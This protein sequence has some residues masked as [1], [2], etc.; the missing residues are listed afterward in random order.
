MLKR[1]TY[2]LLFLSALLL[3]SLPAIGKTIHVPAQQPTIQAGINAASN[4]D[5]VLVSAG[6]YYES[7][8]FSGKAITVTSASGPAVTMIDGPNNQNNS[9]VT[10]SS[11]ETLS[12]VISGFTI[13]SS[14]GLGININGSSPTVKGNVITLSCTAISAFS[15]AAPLIQ[16]NLIA[17]NDPSSCGYGGGGISAEE[18]S[19]VQILGNV[20]SANG[21]TAIS[22]YQASGSV[23]VSQNTV[24]QNNGPGVFIFGGGGP[25]TVIQNLITGNQGSGLSW[26]QPPMTLISNTVASNVPGCCGTAGSEINASDVDNTVVLENNLVVATGTAPAFYCGYEAV[27]PTL[28]NNDIFS[29]NGVAYGGACPDVT[30][31]SGNLSSDPL[32]VDFLSDN[33]L[34]Q[35]GSPAVNAGTN[36]APNEPTTDFV[37]DPRIV[38]GTIDIGA[39]EYSPTPSLALASYA[40]HFGAVDVG[41]SSS[42]Q[43][44]TLTNNST[45]AVSISLI[46]TGA[47]Y[48][49]TNTCGK[50]LAAGGSCQISVTFTPVSGGAVPGALGI[51]TGAT[52]NPL[53]V[54]LL[55][56]GLAPQVQIYGNFYFYGQVIGTPATQTGTL[57]NVG[58]GPLAIS[59]IVYNGASDFVETNNC[60]IAPNTLAVQ[61]YCTISVTYTPTIIGSESGTIAFNDNALPSPQTVNVQGS[62]VSAGV[63]TLNPT[64]LTFPTTLIG[65]SSTPQ[66][67][68]LTNTGT[69][70]LGVSNIYSYGDFP[71]T[72]NC[73]ASLAVNASCT[74]TVTYTPSVQGSENGYVEMDTDSVQ[75]YASF[76]VT[77]TGLAPVPTITSLSLTSVP[78]GSSDTQFIITGTGFV[79]TSQ[80]VW[81]GVPLFGDNY[82][83]GTTQFNVTIPAANLTTP[84]TYQISI[85]TPAPGGGT[86]NALPFTVYTPINYSAAST[87]YSYRTITGTSLGLD[88]YYTSAPITSPFPIQFGGGSYT[89]LTVGA[90]GIISFNGF[91]SPYNDVIPTTE[92]SLLVAPFWTA[93]LPFGTGN[94]NNIFWAV[95]GNSPDRELVVEWRDV[96]YCCSY[97][98]QNTIKFE[99]VFF[100][101]SSNIL[102][103]YAD[104][105]FGGQ[106]S[107]DDNGATATA[108]VQVAPGL[109]TQYSYDTPSLKSGTALLWF[110][111]SPTA[112]LSSSNL[113]FGYHQIGTKSL[114]QK[115]TLTNGGQV[116]LV[117]SG[118]TTGNADFT[119]LNDCGASVKPGKSC[120]IRVY[121]TP[122]LPSSEAATLTITDNAINSPQTASLSGIGTITPIVVYPIMANFGSVKVGTTSTVPVVLANA[123]NRPLS[124]Q[125]ITASPGVYTETNNCGASLEAGASCTVSVTFAP[126]QQGN[127][128]GKLAMGLNGKPPVDEVK[129]V[130]SGQ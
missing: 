55:G 123:A 56:T 58:Q 82:P 97:N 74:I 106:Y 62:S 8:N 15:D 130:G 66:S 47:S 111:S 107:I 120:S 92:T 93:L 3:C 35:S 96:T 4:G 100:E 102:F 2:A 7:I 21:G 99:V 69:G 18:N 94:D 89:N 112:T 126:T 29:A 116:P 27:A 98:T 33:Y 1:N 22:V 42:P 52:L 23:N 122:S 30:G 78:A 41:S 121:F 65:Q 118:I 6:T 115:V 87:K 9:A 103:N 39:D 110:P 83:N 104:T 16:G 25:V 109:G 71:E 125:Q 70:P 101:G 31:T 72:N 88:S 12:S 37:G 24:T 36:S 64:S 95:T 76:S 53:A 19:P 81:N 11:G 90:S 38:N 60:P 79:N 28:E 45:S 85:L 86:S 105:V 57:T 127:V 67:V 128:I 51:F 20:V 32:F 17:G 108:G 75:S 73:P 124:I 48:S 40:L 10:F 68:T 114:A 13:Q 63:P 50:S 5:T 46:A 119:Q 59:S 49:Q 34:I 113:G 43:T 14:S 84:G 44:V 129:L 54:N 80:L 117:I 77:G 91:E 61:A 26:Y